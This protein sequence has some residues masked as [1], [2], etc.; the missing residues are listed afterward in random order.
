MRRVALGGAVALSAADS[1]EL[2]SEI[3]R[4]EQCDE[5]GRHTQAVDWLVAGVRRNDVEAITRL[6]KR[7]LIGD[8]APQ[9]PR[10][11]AQFLVDAWR[12]GGAE[13]AAVLAVCLAT[14]INNPPDLVAGW[15]CLI[16]AAVRG[17][18]PAQQQL[19][20][21]AGDPEWADRATP[22]GNAEHWRRLA[23]GVDLSKWLNVPKSVDLHGDPLIRSYPLFIE[24]HISRW[25]I[26]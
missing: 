6:G 4:A 10:E 13:A 7:L 24:P 16:T 26:Q 11:G 23:Q 15:E 25:I 18:K 17:W 22:L 21:L 19:R 3:V 1:F 5:A 12:R 14:G 2:S 8:R 9:L 20:V